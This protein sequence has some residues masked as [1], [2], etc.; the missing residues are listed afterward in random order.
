M[1]FLKASK[2]TTYTPNLVAVTVSLM[3]KLLNM[4]SLHATTVQTEGSQT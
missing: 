3:V 1:I 2:S 4:F